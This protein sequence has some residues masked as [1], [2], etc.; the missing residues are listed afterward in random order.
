MAITREL[1]L[2]WLALVASCVFVLSAD[3]GGLRKVWELQ[4]T[5]VIPPDGIRNDLRM[6]VFALRFSPDGKRL[7]VVSDVHRIAAQLTSH[8]TILNIDRPANG[9][10]TFDISGTAWDNERTGISPYFEWSSDGEFLV[11]G[12]A[13]V[14]LPEG[15][16]CKLPKTAVVVL[17]N[18]LIGTPLYGTEGP[19]R[20]ITYDTNCRIVDQWETGQVWAISAASAERGLLLMEPLPDLPGTRIEKAGRILV[21][22]LRKSVVRRFGQEM[23]GS[24]FA[25]KGK[26]LCAAVRP[27]EHGSF[28]PRCYDVDN[29]TKIAQANGI[30]GGVPIAAASLAS[31]VVASDVRVKP[32]LFLDY[33]HD[34]Y[35]ARRVVWEIRTGKELAAWKPAK[36]EY[37]FPALPAP[38]RAKGYFTFTISPDGEYIAEGGNG[39]VRLYKIEP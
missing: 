6:P 5:T 4:L 13:V 21:D 33:N 27:S 29:G 18:R 25:E 30:N 34:D 14:R 12:E 38:T 36:Q 15:H 35:T 7:A 39:I 3:A 1:K 20:L 16:T 32:F 9:A 11:A 24:V 8:L 28:P 19:W 10:K 37:E 26:V 22:A 31:R 23:A 17:G 2:L